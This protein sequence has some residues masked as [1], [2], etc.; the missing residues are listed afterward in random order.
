MGK[1]RLNERDAAGKDPFATPEG[2]SY[3]PRRPT[4]LAD[5]VP[6]ME[7][8]P[9]DNRF[10]L[11]REIGGGAMGQVWLA[12]DLAEEELE[13]GE[14]YKA[15]KVVNPLLQ[16][17]PRPLKALKTEA[18]RASR[19]SH[20]NIINVYG[21]RQG[22]DGWLFVVM[23]YLEGQDLDRLLLEEG[24]P[25]LSWERS[26]ALL[27]PI[28][29]ALDYAHAHHTIH[30]DLKP[31]NVFITK[32]GEVKLLDFGL[33]YRLH[34]SSSMVNVR[35]TGSS[36]TPQYMPPEAFM[37]GEQ[38]KARD[39][40][41]LA[42]LVYEM[43]TGEPPYTPEAAVGR[44]PDMLP[45]R[46][47]E[48]TEAAWEV[49]KAG[50]A[51]RKEERPGSAS[52][53]VRRLEDA[54]AVTKRKAIKSEEKPPEAAPISEP[55]PGENAGHLSRRGI[56]KPWLVGLMVLVIM[57]TG[58]YFW[59][60]QQSVPPFTTTP[61]PVPAP[62]PA[63]EPA[64]TPSKPTTE[65]D[66]ATES[67]TAKP[68]LPS[69]ESIHGW[70]A[71]AEKVKTLQQQTAEA[72]GTS[73]EFRDRLK[74]GSRGPE[75]VVIPAGEFLMGS[76]EDEDGRNTDE[77]QHRV[78]IEQPFAIGKHEVTFAEYDRFAGTTGR[79]K[80]DDNG[81]GRGSRPVI[82]VSWNDAVAYAEWLSEQ[83]GQKYRL[84]TEAEWEYACRASSSGLYS[85]GDDE[86]RL[87]N[88]AW[89][90]GS[91]DGQPQPVGQKDPNG[92]GLYD[93]HGNIWEWVQDWYGPY[94]ADSVTNP[95]GPDAGAYRVIRGGV[96]S[97][98]AQH[99]RAAFRGWRGPG[100]HRGVGFRCAMS[101]P[102]K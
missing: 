47:E 79:D 18:L 41:A 96:W 10:R 89:Y 61:K 8:G 28:A 92:W 45:S 66:K 85:F 83:T 4:R 60:E 62:K 51:Y 50:F 95:F 42:C 46:P 20:P 12:H 19:L 98:P 91:A 52:E 67:P 86:A 58:I 73:V 22:R 23:D 9:E 78:A 49:L 17:L 81:W 44:S 14:R 88:Y 54:Q 65:V 27:K 21:W 43:L 53:L 26:L 3:R 70:S 74:D 63:T 100:G 59:L 71:E 76:P 6:G 1:D 29:E 13:G 40:Y 64:P 5:L 30:C 93:M 72:L 34:R 102:S 39:I 77:R 48:L 56:G 55:Q 69:V 80:P 36:G 15:L 57:A 75:M 11:V 7:I 38:H 90:G 35:E 31:G 99:V 87:G 97:S 84:P 2:D 101:V 24:Q 94:A 32:E 37:A 82:N 16:D 25:G 68:E 33:A